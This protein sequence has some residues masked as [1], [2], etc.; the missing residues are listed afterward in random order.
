MSSP[1]SGPP[2][3]S[4]LA[5]AALRKHRSDCRKLVSKQRRLVCFYSNPVIPFEFLYQP[6]LKNLQSLTSFPREMRAAIN[7]VSSVDILLQ[8]ATTID[9]MRA[10]VQT[11][12][13][14][15][16][17]WSGHTFEGE[18]VFESE[19]GRI[20]VLPSSPD[21]SH[22]RI[23]TCDVDTFWESLSASM[24]LACVVLAACE[25]K[26]FTSNLFSR[27]RERASG[28]GRGVSFV[29]WATVVDDAAAAAFARATYDYMRGVFEEEK[30]FDEEELFR[31]GLQGVVDAGFRFADPMAYQPRQR[32]LY[33]GVPVL[34][35]ADA[36]GEMLTRTPSA[37]GFAEAGRV[38][39]ELEGAP[40]ET[41]RPPLR[42]IDSKKENT[43]P[44]GLP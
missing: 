15:V 1:K 35:T 27:S 3:L 9:T 17:Y 33:A 6:H 31:V 21:Y 29:C 32:R 10:T 16:V 22:L 13:P 7:L 30:N 37:F 11:Y 23:M 40:L 5:Y 36:R 34:V 2:D 20:Q 44:N 42:R 38:D 8:P 18:P 12:Q 43:D 4:A 25:S 39:E 24:N 28:A 14:G 26:V 19:E 41:P